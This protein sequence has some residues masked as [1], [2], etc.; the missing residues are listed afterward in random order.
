MN[1]PT[2]RELPRPWI[3]LCLGLVAIAAYA[4]FLYRHALN[5]PFANDIVDVLQVL[6][7][8]M[9]ATDSDAVLE[10]LFAQ[11]NDHR[12]AATR[13]L[14]WLLWQ[15]NGEVDFRL[16]TFV[17]NSALL[18]LLGL[19][20]VALRR[21]AGLAWLLCLAALL[22]FQLR[23]YGITLWPMAAFA[24][25]YVYLYGFASL[26]LLRRSGLLSFALALI[27][28]VLATFTL[29]S[30]Q[31]L[32]L[33]GLVLLCQQ[34]WLGRWRHPLYV[35]T[36]LLAMLL[37][38]WAWRLGLETPNTMGNVLT[39]MLATPGHH[40]LYFF[41]LLGSALSES[42]LG[43]AALAGF[44]MFLLLCLSTYRQRHSRDL[45][46]ET[47]GW[48]IVLSTAAMVLGRASFS[49]VDYALGSR[50]SF[51]SV[52]MLANSALIMAVRLGPALAQGAQP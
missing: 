10:A 2:A 17:A 38:L 37:T 18:G 12:T 27:F 3:P 16:L 26:L 24:Y 39:H 51:P 13:G 36:W 41:T 50:Y 33:V 52:L 47:L 23:A 6:L 1:L 4:A 9:S 29:A 28:A 8:L 40:L 7:S 43:A 48:Y 31:T 25:F 45:A 44:G 22:L 35:L 20:A 5:I 21:E 46:L 11:H 30:G 15:G 32:W 34:C 42:H 49:E 14:Y 19:Y